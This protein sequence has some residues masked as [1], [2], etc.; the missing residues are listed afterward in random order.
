[1]GWHDRVALA[2]LGIEP[3]LWD[4]PMRAEAARAEAIEHALSSCH[5]ATRSD[6]DKDSTPPDA[7]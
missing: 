5:A 2:K 7:A 1:M 3:H 6:V 4:V